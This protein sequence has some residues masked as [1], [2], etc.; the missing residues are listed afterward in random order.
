MSQ[1]L[2][3]WSL[4]LALA[5]VIGPLGCENAPPKEG[6]AAESA[7]ASPEPAAEA[8]PTPDA[9][10]K[11]ESPAEPEPVE[12][13]ETFSQP[14]DLVWRAT[15]DTVE[16]RFEIDRRDPEKGLIITRY[17]GG[18]TLL[19]PWDIDAQDSYDALEETLN[20][21]RRRCTAQVTRRGDEVTVTIRIVRERLN[22]EPPPTAHA[23]TP[24]LT[25]AERE[26]MLTQARFSRK[27]RWT[28]MGNDPRLGQKVLHDIAERIRKA[29]VGQPLSEPKPI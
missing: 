14:Y 2:V 4:V 23:V 27:E 5:L 17:K 29:E 25:D 7:E 28:F 3:A 9:P 20:R 16:S 10:A 1:K 19:E 26:Q 12:C 13:A 18:R 6:Q 22:Y 21:V 24:A 8:E 15:V 11:E